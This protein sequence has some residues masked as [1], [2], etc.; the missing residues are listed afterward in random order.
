MLLW[1]PRNLIDE[2][3]PMLPAAAIEDALQL[4]PTLTAIEV[5]DT[6]HYLMV[7][8]PRESAM[9]ADAIRRAL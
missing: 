4:A 5:P 6:N 8:R 2:P 9:A 1:A 3:K 7:F